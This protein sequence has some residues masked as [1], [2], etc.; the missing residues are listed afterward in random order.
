[1]G[2]E[3]DCEETTGDTEPDD[4]RSA[5]VELPTGDKTLKESA[6]DEV[7]LQKGESTHMDEPRNAKSFR[8]SPTGGTGGPDAG[9]PSEPERLKTVLA[10]KIRRAVHRSR[11][12]ARERDLHN[13][14][15]CEHG[16]ERAAEG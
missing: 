16:R 10:F 2:G 15:T 8:S 6:E 9:R 3:A 5:S 4:E 13:D 11:S 14:A 1:M 7:E 12:G